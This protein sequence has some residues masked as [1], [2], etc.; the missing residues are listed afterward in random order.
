M[1]A[2]PR[3]LDRARGAVQQLR[4]LSAQLRGVLA[5]LSSSDVSFDRLTKVV[6]RDGLLAAAFLRRANSALY[7]L[8]TSVRS[9]RQALTLMGTEELRRFA[10][11]LSSASMCPKA[12][13]APGFSRRKYARHALGTA[14]MAGLIERQIGYG[15]ESHAYL[16]GLLHDIS[17]LAVAQ[18]LPEEYARLTRDGR[19]DTAREAEV[20][21]TSHGELSAIVLE[22]WK[23]PGEVGLA[24]TEHHGATAGRRPSLAAVLGAADDF[25]AVL[26]VRDEPE[27]SEF[28]EAP[29]YQL[30]IDATVAELVA[31]F[32]R[33]FD[34]TRIPADS[35]ASP[36]RSLRP[37]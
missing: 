1:G 29:L 25:S 11:S 33:Q 32:H 7:Q 22:E 2:C 9:V 6:E 24:V 21:G 8:E 15:R 28:D 16:A 5:E 31:E 35:A 36:E 12:V 19:W 34:L 14:I 10:L 27:P 37:C 3:V 23:V 30:G 20:L 4:P 13:T 26:T 17:R 18:A